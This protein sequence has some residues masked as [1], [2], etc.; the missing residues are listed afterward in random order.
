[1]RPEESILEAYWSESIFTSL[2]GNIM[3]PS[4][5]VEVKNAAQEGWR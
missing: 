2:I 5:R 3:H 1:M 4:H